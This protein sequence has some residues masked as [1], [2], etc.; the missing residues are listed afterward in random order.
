MPIAL[1]EFDLDLVHHRLVRGPAGRPQEAKKLHLPG[2]SVSL[3]VVIVV[4]IA[5]PVF[6]ALLAL[7]LRAA[8]RAAAR[9]ADLGHLGRPWTRRRGCRWRRRFWHKRKQG[10]EQR[11]RCGSPLRGIFAFPLTLLRGGIEC[12]DSAAGEAGHAGGKVAEAAELRPLNGHHAQGPAEEKHQQGRPAP[13]GPRGGSSSSSS[14]SGRSRSGTRRRAID[15][16][17]I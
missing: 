8:S 11:C 7:Q 5:L 9:R 16:C 2:R 10:R 3:L 17:L 15:S 6:R 4:N 12:P 14:S 1:S 13:R